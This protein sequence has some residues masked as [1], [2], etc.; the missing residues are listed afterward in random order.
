MQPAGLLARSGTQ[1]DELRLD[2]VGDGELAPELGSVQQ[3]ELKGAVGSTTWID[4][5]SP[6]VERAKKDK[7]EFGRTDRLSVWEA[8][9]RISWTTIARALLRPVWPRAWPAN[10]LAGCV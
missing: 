8:V 9:T 3:W 6:K 10:A 7:R 1:G 4:S 5:S 2:D